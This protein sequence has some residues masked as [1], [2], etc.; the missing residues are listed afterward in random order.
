MSQWDYRPTG[1]PLGAVM[2]PELDHELQGG[3]QQ[4]HRSSETYRPLLFPNDSAAHG[5]S[6]LSRFR[7]WHRRQA[8]EGI[9]L[10]ADKGLR[11]LELLQATILVT[12]SDQLNARWVDLWQLAASCLRLAVPM[13]LYQSHALSTNGPAEIG[14]I[15]CGDTTD[16]LEQAEKDRTWWMAFLMERTATMWSTWPLS[17]A[18]EEIMTELPTTQSAYDAGHGELM[19]TQSIQDPDLYSKHPE[20][21]TDSLCFLIKAIKLFADSQRFFRFYQ[22]RPHS[23]E[24]YLDEP[25]LQI[26]LSQ[27]NAYRLSLPEHVRRPTNKLMSGQRLDVDQLAAV[28]SIHATMIVIAEP[29]VA[30]QTWKYDLASLGLRAVRAILS[31]VYD[32]E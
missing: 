2:H 5:G 7:L 22:R 13:R 8:L 24:R 29:L 32:S 9:A 27:V 31:L 25:G 3:K 21:H 14:Q 30:K 6:G 12:A 16:T 11:Y 1:T 23:V 18:D 10:Y 15:Q 17:L 20:R 19:G 26:L 28:M 4:E